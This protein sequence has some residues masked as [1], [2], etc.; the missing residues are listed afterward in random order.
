MF[1]IQL[2]SAVLTIA[3]PVIARDFAVPVVSLSLA[4]TIYLTMMIAGLPISGWAADRF[5]ARRV[6]ILSALGFAFFSLTCALAES[7]WPFII[8]R[9]L[10][11]LTASMLAPV[12]RLILLRRSSKHELIDAMAITTMPMLIAPTIGPS[13]GGL[14]IEH[15]SWEFV[16]LMNIPFALLL[17]LVSLLRLPPM[18]ADPHRRLDGLGAVLLT[19]TL[20]AVLTGFDR[21]ADGIARPLPWLLIGG[22]AVAGWFT[23]RHL[24]A[25]A[26][27]IVEFGA[28]RSR[29]F[30]SAAIGAGAVVRMPHRAILF[31][32]PLMFQLGFGYSPFVAGLM[33]MALNGGDM[34][35]KPV[36]KPAI[37]RFGFRNTMVAGS[38]LGL[39][40]I[41]VVMA[42]ERGEWTV[43]TI[44]AVLFAAGISRSIVFTGMVSM[45]YVTLSDRLIN[46]GNVLSAISMQ[47]G[48]ALGVS[49]TALVL[50]ASTWTHG[51]D[52]P[53]L[54]DFRLTLLAIVVV[55][56]AS[57]VAL[58]RSLPHR[59]E[60]VHGESDT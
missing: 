23:W 11:G 32:L 4:I 50:S 44:L 7:Y 39:A 53:A 45:A 43:P 60:E 13:L 10:Q 52:E 24:R 5:G 49:A 34:I 29:M 48:N 42:L 38:L 36:I 15:A 37:D 18:A 57:T 35:S 55:G 19:G 46:S 20:I 28:M 17:V 22:G 59:L 33:L 12:G 58:W 54:I 3:L 2:D 6:Y 31:A 21:L 51:H 40:G 26:H 47:I 16:F 9:A 8:S 41:T 30:R 1:M 56:I 27:P 14:I 25:H